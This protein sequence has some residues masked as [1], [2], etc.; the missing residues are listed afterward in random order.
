MIFNDENTL[1]AFSMP[2]IHTFS[3][4]SN[5]IGDDFQGTLKDRPNVLLMGD[6]HGDPNMVKDQD[7]TNNGVCLRYFFNINFRSQISFFQNF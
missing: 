6:S 7:L 3:K 1:T 5:S 4:N 2:I